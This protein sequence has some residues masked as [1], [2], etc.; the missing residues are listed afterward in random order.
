M[1]G[2]DIELYP[3]VKAAGI[4]AIIRRTNGSCGTRRNVGGYS[5]TDS[6][7]FHLHMGKV[8]GVK[9]LA[10]ELAALT[11]GLPYVVERWTLDPTAFRLRGFQSGFTERGRSPASRC[12]TSMTRYL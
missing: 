5:I 7:S 2:G 9:G 11:A 3:R 8:G 6:H 12:P 4:Q 10:L 1:G